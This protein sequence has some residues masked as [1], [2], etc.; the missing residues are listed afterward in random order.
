MYFYRGY[1]VYHAVKLKTSRHCIFICIELIWK[2]Q[3]I[4]FVYFFSFNK[5]VENYV[6]SVK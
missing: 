1:D 6:E 2:I 5:N 4:Q 3:K